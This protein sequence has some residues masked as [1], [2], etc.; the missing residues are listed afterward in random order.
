MSKA[1]YDKLFAD[2]D[3]QS[4]VED[5]ES[6]NE[7]KKQDEENGTPEEM[8]KNASQKAF[9]DAMPKREY[10]APAYL[11]NDKYRDK[12][13]QENPSITKDTKFQVIK[14]MEA[15]KQFAEKIVE[16]WNGYEDEFKVKYTA[17][18]NLNP[19]AAAEIESKG[20][21]NQKSRRDRKKSRPRS[22]KG[23]EPNPDDSPAI[24]ELK[25]EVKTLQSHLHEVQATVDNVYSHL[26][27]VLDNNERRKRAR[28][29]TETSN[30]Q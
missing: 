18:K 16:E 22:I 9:K 2:D 17:W 28:S 5:D 3:V 14:M 13:I 25:K 21:T 6:V 15:H 1:D 20:K 26:E 10:Q 29:S 8:A 30:G 19:K 12:F 24:L 27:K 11:Y 7:E 23:I 4:D